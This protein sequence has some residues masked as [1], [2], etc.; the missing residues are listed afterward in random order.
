MKE[1][2]SKIN[3]MYRELKNPRNDGWVQQSSLEQL[4]EIE[5]LI[6]SFNLKKEA[7]R[8][9]IDSL[10]IENYIDDSI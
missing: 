5:S 10:D 3:N 9:K 1:I 8:F 6:S 4:L 2:R 7:L